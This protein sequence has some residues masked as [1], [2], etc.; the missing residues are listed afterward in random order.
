MATTDITTLDPNSNFFIVKNQIFSPIEITSS[1]DISQLVDESYS[2]SDL[3]QVEILN[4]L[5]KNKI[6]DETS[7]KQYYLNIYQQLI[8]SFINGGSNSVLLR[9]SSS[10]TNYS[11]L[12]IFKTINFLDFLDIQELK[13]SV[14]NSLSND[15]CILLDSKPKQTIHP[16][17]QQF[18]KTNFISLCRLHIGYL[19]ICN[20][21][22]STVFDNSEF[23][24]NDTTF[25]DFA[26]I[27]FKQQM[28]RLIP[29]YYNS[30]KVF[31]YDELNDLLESGTEFIDDLTGKEYEFN[32]PLNDDNLETNIDKYLNYLF[33]QQ[34]KFVANKYNTAFN[35]TIL[36]ADEVT[37]FVLYPINNTKQ[38]LYSVQDY[39]FDNLPIITINTDESI[40][41]KLESFVDANKYLVLLLEIS[42]SPPTEDTK[43]RNYKLTLNLLERVS[44]AFF[45]SYT[46][47]EFNGFS[48]STVKSVNKDSDYPIL[49]SSELSEILLELKQPFLEL[50]FLKTLTNYCFPLNKILN[51]S[52][53]FYIQTNMKLYENISKAIEGSVKTIDTVNNM[54]LGNEDKI[55][56]EKPDDPL[57]L[58]NPILGINLEIAK[59][60]AQAPIQIL[61]G[62]EETYD[63][64]I[65]IASKL[66]DLSVAA[67][68]PPT[69][70]ALWS[71]ALLP[72]GT[73]PPPVGIG[74]P[75]IPPWG[76]IYW[77]VDAGEVLTSYVKNGFNT[78]S[79]ATVEL[80]AKISISDN[81]FKNKNC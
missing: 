52:S 71:L 40:I 74:P 33:N 67:G 55:D 62:L 78:N 35:Q 22:L 32:F 79:K 76:Y 63:P 16:L 39:F 46:L 60:I 26:F 18:L 70:V 12:D 31:L 58:D 45:T 4:K 13:N 17:K 47:N 57:S 53:F 8:K 80:K 3:N 44:T 19:K 24:K 64:N 81:P 43:L 14:I 5:L 75:L 72:V 7:L 59:M 25:V 15:P 36:D 42:D 54:I 10:E 30:I 51:I 41:T 69:P 65:A 49:G 29:D 1:T 23:Y 38:S 20:L 21:Y 27:T 77:G 50:N 66:R 61:K 2:T 11:G 34:H 37:N 6:T 56:C 9:E 68:L 28:V 48:V 73:I